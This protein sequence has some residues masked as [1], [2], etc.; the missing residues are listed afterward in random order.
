MARISCT[1][2]ILCIPHLLED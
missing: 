1:R 2:H